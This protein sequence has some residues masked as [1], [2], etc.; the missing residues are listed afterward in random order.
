LDKQDEQLHRELFQAQ[1]A[2]SPLEPVLR[3]VECEIAEMEFLGRNSSTQA[4]IYVAAMMPQNPL[5]SKRI[6]NLG[7]QQN[8]ISSSLNLHCMPTPGW[9]IRAGHE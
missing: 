4:L 7:I 5:G 2:L 1:E 6:S 9:A 3:Q 8:F